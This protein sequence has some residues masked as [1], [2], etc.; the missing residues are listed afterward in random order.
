MANF[1]GRV[2]L[3]TG[4]SVGLGEGAPLHFAKKGA[5]L[6]L[7]GRDT[8]RLE[9]VAKRCLECGIPDGDIL[10]LTGDLT[11]AAFRKTTIEKTV[12]KFGSLDVLVNNAGL[13]FPGESMGMSETQYDQTMDLN[14]K[15]PFLLS[16]LAVP[17]LEKTQGNIVN[18]TSLSGYRAMPEIGI[19][20]VS[21]AVLDMFTQCLALEL[22]PKKVR[23]NSVSPS[24]VPT[25]IFG[26][27]GS[28]KEASV[29]PLGR[30]GTPQDVAE[31][32]GYLASDA[33]S[34]VTGQILL[35][36]GGRVC[37]FK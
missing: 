34:Y 37:A 36:D 4:A 5:K 23:V 14:M 6:S 7:T 21:K 26:R 20:C 3:I 19:Y 28:D 16:Q 33:A 8:T 31:A 25:A 13:V 29:N 30:L 11:D 24:T 2:V 22:A 27:E 35:G 18:I 1:A 9:G 10:T 32:V 17:N 15:V 12:A